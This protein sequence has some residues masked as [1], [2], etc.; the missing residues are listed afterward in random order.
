[1]SG[2][3]CAHEGGRPSVSSYIDSDDAQVSGI[4]PRATGRAARGGAIGIVGDLDHV[5]LVVVLAAWTCEPKVER[6]RTWAEHPRNGGERRVDLGI[7]I[8]GRADDRGVHA[9]RY[10]VDEHPVVDAR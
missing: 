7:T 10:V 6:V 5:G 2:R 8:F 3:E 1:M 4:E 9:Q